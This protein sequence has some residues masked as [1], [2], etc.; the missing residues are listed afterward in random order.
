MAVIHLMTVIHCTSQLHVI[1]VIQF[2]KSVRYTIIIV[3]IHLITV[4]DFHQ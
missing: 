1:A 2:H 3:V 4:I